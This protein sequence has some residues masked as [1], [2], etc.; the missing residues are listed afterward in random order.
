MA[1]G[2][3]GP[4]GYAMAHPEVGECDLQLVGFAEFVSRDK[5]RLCS[6]MMTMV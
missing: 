1:A 5:E 2:I 3:S 4:E 6:F